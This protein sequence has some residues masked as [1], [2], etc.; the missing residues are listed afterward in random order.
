MVWPILISV[1]V[2]PGP[3]WGAPRAATP[4]INARLAEAPTARILRSDRVPMPFPPG[5]RARP[6]FDLTNSESLPSRRNRVAVD[7]LSAREPGHAA[8]GS[9]IMAKE[10]CLSDRDKVPLPPGEGRVRE[11]SQDVRERAE[12]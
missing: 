5:V 8:R 10:R 1:S 4:A 7:D 11:T 3:Y 2:T 12:G 9:P 6:R